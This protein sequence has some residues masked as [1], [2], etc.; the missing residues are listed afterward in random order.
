MARLA[1]VLVPGIAHVPG[2]DLAEAVDSGLSYTTGGDANW[3]PTNW[4]YH[5]GGDA[6]EG[7][8]WDD[9]ASWL[10]TEVQGA[11]TITFWWKV[12][13]EAN[14]DYLEFYVDDVLKDA[15]SGEVN[16]QQ[17]SYTINTSGTHTLK[18]RYA[19]D[20][21]E[22]SEGDDCG[23]VDQVQWSGQV[24][25]PENWTEIEYVYDAF[26]RRIEKKYDGATVL[27]YIYDGDHCI[28][29]YDA[30]NNLT[31]KYIFGPAV[32]EPICMIEAAGSYAGTYYYHFD[33]LGS[34]VALT[35]SSGN[36]VE[37]YEYDVYGRV[38]ASDPN[39]PNRFMFTG[40]EFDKETGLYY[41]R[42]RY[43]NPQIGRFLQTDPVGY[44]AGMNVYRYCSNNPLGLRDPFGRDP[45]DYND[46]NDIWDSNSIYDA[47]IPDSE[48]AEAAAKR[49]TQ[50][51][52]EA[53]EKDPLW[54]TKALPCG[55][56]DFKYWDPYATY[57]LAD[58]TILNGSEFGNYLAGYGAF[59]H[60][61][62]AGAL[63]VS[64]AGHVDAVV[65]K[66]IVAWGNFIKSVAGGQSFWDSITDPEGGTWFDEE[67]SKSRIR[68]G[69]DDAYQK[70][71]NFWNTLAQ[72]RRAVIGLPKM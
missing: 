16:W 14:S 64:L 55:E 21:D 71:S 10:Q 1:R 58:G 7:T 72:M 29:E 27:K 49:K 40:R 62:P 44:D 68:K 51:I 47:W 52:I 26:G 37:V 70:T 41:Y 11:G 23:W 60:Y 43:Y 8:A 25:Q 39:H 13:S 15:I 42:A 32:D 30:S 65:E 34:A 18:W 24:P 66:E 9:G 3:Q 53:V 6:A 2:G 56:H 48:S 28:A 36:T 61:G 4:P 46:M 33:A 67:A 59:Y 63:A 69:L 20:D 35:N 38:G 54:A 57:I 12:S 45:T 50:E 31:R 17:K 22:Y 5:Y 19:K